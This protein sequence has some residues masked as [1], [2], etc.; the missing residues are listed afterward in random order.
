[1]TSDDI[2]QF[3]IDRETHY[4]KHS[5]KAL[6]A[7][8]NSTKGSSSRMTVSNYVMISLPSYL[9]WINLCSIE[10]AFDKLLNS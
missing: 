5:R 7:S 4:V 1:M 3:F 9:N 10:F 6:S 8:Q 2:P